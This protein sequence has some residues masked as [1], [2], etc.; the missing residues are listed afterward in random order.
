MDKE[1][2]RKAK[3]FVDRRL[4]GENQKFRLSDDGVV[5]D[6]DYNKLKRYALEEFPGSCDERNWYKS[7]SVVLSRISN[8]KR[9][10]RSVELFIFGVWWLKLMELDNDRK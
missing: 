8:A 5:F 1:K 7:M 2:L 3:K 9:F 4:A 6:C 10:S